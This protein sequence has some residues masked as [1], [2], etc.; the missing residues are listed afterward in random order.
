MVAVL[1][2]V[3]NDRLPRLSIFLSD[4]RGTYLVNSFHPEIPDEILREAAG[5]SLIY[6]PI[7][8]EDRWLEKRFMHY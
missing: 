4:F 2:E 3:S 7:C 8:Y 6:G 1:E 5:N